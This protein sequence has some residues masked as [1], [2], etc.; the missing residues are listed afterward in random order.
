MRWLAHATDT[1]TGNKET[2]SMKTTSGDETRVGHDEIA[3]LARQ[4]WER[5]GRKPGRDLENWLEAERQLLSRRN[6]T[7]RPRENPVTEALS[8]KAPRKPIRL[9]DAAI[10]PSRNK[11]SVTRA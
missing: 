5:E 10:K 2:L 4:I 6:E 3:N 9:P 1:V 7:S 8:S 11:L